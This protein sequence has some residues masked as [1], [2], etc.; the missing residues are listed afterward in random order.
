MVRNRGYVIAHAPRDMK[1]VPTMRPTATKRS[2]NS[3]PTMT[4]MA[5]RWYKKVTGSV[6]NN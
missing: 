4:P 1:A 5:G 3:Q 2:I 6:S